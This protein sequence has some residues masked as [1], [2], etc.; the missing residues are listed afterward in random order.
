[1]NRQLGQKPAEIG[2][3]CFGLKELWTC[4]P[5]TAKKNTRKE[6]QDRPVCTFVTVLLSQV[7]ASGNLKEFERLYE[8]DPSRLRLQDSKGWNVF[9]HAASKA[10]VNI[11]QAILQHGG[12]R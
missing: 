3:M 2:N 5:N 9:H 6:R 4:D 8:A 7:A 11:M 12:G 10:K 1:M